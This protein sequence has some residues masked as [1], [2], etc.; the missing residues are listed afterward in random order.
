MRGGPMG[1]EMIHSRL[2]HKRCERFIGTYLRY[3]RR[4]KCKKHITFRSGNVCSMC[5]RSYTRV[6][7]RAALRRRYASPTG[8][9]CRGH[10]GVHRAALGSALRSHL[11]TGAFRKA[12]HN[13]S[14]N[15]SQNRFARSLDHTS[16]W[17]DP[18]GGG[19]GWVGGGLIRGCHTVGA[20]DCGHPFATGTSKGDSKIT[21]QQH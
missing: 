21:H 8:G 1:H 6:L 16:S 4:S 17:A 11:E 14:Q 3:Y 18:D 5:A 15:S 9:F 10:S 13:Q 12:N 7:S 19:W 2:A 20:R